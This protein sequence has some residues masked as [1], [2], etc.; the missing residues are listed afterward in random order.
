MNNN[1]YNTYNSF[2]KKNNYK[3]IIGFLLII[4]AFVLI[5]LINVV[6]K[7]NKIYNQKCPSLVNVSLFTNNKNDKHYAEEG[8]T[9]YL[10]FNSTEKL[11][12]LPKVEINGKSVDVILQNGKY[13]AMYTVK[14]DYNSN[15]EVYFLIYDYVDNDGNSGD[16]VQS[17]SDNSTVII[18]E[19]KNKMDNVDVSYITLNINNKSININESLRLIA[20]IEPTNATNKTVTWTSSNNAVATIS[21]EGVV[22]G[23]H[24]GTTTIT[25]TCGGKSAQAIIEVVKSEIKLT[26]VKLNKTS[27]KIY[28]NSNVKTVSLNA[29]IKPSNATNKKVTWKSSNNAVA[30]VSNTGIVT[31]KSPGNTIIT[32]TSSDGKCADSFSLTVKE[33]IVIVITASQG[34]YMNQNISQYTNG[35][36]QHNY[37]KEDNMFFIYKSG[38]GFDFQVGDGLSKAKNILINNFELYKKH[39]EISLFFTMTGN[40][41]NDYT[42]SSITTEKYESI[43]N[44][45]SNSV[46]VIKDMGYDVNGY[47]ISHS[48]LQSKHKNAASKKIVYS[49]NSNACEKKYRSNWKYYLSNQKMKSVIKNYNN[50]RFIDNY[51]KY[52]IIKDEQAKTFTW[53]RTYTTIDALH[54]DESTTKDYMNLVFIEAGI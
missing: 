34:K 54:W 43:A 9:I 14:G 12:K 15:L 33:K 19:N 38:S 52:L 13:T 10:T 18:R 20:S 28:L 8:D 30:I 23:K 27:G 5:F 4:F 41:V 48:P 42:C 6:L 32:V 17:T 53:L 29:T 44:N 16:I 39:V 21:K 40:S 49:T 26:G 36:T 31:A 11:N 35:N 51:S 22:T 37:T 47:V 45:Y 50:L 46:K 3:Y 25:A 1:M 7:Y 2:S 24:P